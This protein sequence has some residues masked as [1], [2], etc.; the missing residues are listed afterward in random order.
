MSCGLRRGCQ[1]VVTSTEG[2]QNV[3][4]SPAMLSFL[5]SSPSQLLFLLSGSNEAARSP[6]DSVQK[7]VPPG[8]RTGSRGVQRGHGAAAENIQFSVSLHTIARGWMIM[9]FQTSYQHFVKWHG[10]LQSMGSQTVRLNL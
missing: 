9:L 3:N 10:M 4:Q 5:P 8:P 7:G 6:A 2:A 1:P